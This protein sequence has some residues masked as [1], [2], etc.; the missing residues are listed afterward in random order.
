MRRNALR[1][2][3]PYALLLCCVGYHITLFVIE[4]GD[5][6]ATGF[7]QHF[8]DQV[9]ALMQQGAV[10]QHQ[11]PTL[12]AF[13]VAAVREDA[14]GAFGSQAAGAKLGIG[15]ASHIGISSR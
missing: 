14:G 10:R 6:E 3:T 2:L 5:A 1:L 7:A 12:E 11:R 15:C 13:V 9:L 8:A 4:V